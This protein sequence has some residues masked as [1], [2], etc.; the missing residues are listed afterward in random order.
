MRLKAR[1]KTEGFFCTGV[2]QGGFVRRLRFLLTIGAVFLA[3]TG[4]GI[5]AQGGTDHTPDPKAPVVKDL[6]VGERYSGGI[7]VRSPFLGVSFLVPTDWRASLPAGTVV[8]LDSSLHPGLGFV[9]LLSDISRDDLLAKLSEPQAIEAGFVLHPVGS[10][11]EQGNQ[12]HATYATEHDVAVTV[13]QL[14]R[15]RNS[16][17]YQFVGRK[18]DENLYRRVVE[19]LAASTEFMPP[20][21]LLALRAWYE[22]LSG[23]MLTPDVPDHGG[24]RQTAPTIHLCSDGR[25]ISIMKLAPVPGRTTES[26]GEDYHETGTWLIQQE[27]EDARLVLTRGEGRS[28]IHGLRLEQDHLLLDDQQRESSPSDQCF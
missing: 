28:R 13:A 12:F 9:H 27:R 2:S 7:R 11:R 20:D 4:S 23:M 17:V 16:V 10:V 26:D 6:R 5:P 25:F 19:E 22:R 3:T 8:F 24:E 14:D 1:H 15:S 18:S 21:Q